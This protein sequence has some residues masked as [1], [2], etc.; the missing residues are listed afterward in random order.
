MRKFWRLLFI[1]MIILFCI[2]SIAIMLG[3]A[4]LYKYSDSRVSEELLCA[5]RSYDE[6]KFYCFDYDDRLYQTGEAR[7]IKDASLNSGIEYKYTSY[8][9]MPENLVLAFVAVEDKR[10]YTHKGIDYKRSLGAVLNYVVGGKKSFG[11]STITQQLVKNLTGNNAMLVERKLTEAFSAMELEKSFEKSEIIEMYL[12]IIN[13]SRGCR[14]VGAAAEFYFSKS[15]SELDLREC[16]CLA[17][18]TNNPS[19]YDPIAHPEANKRRRDI[20]L[21]CM[22]DAGYISHAQY[23]T[24]VSQETRITAKD[25]SGRRINSWYIDAVIRDVISDFAAKYDI[26][27]E[28]ASVLLYKGGYRIYT[29]MDAEIQSIL[30]DHFADLGNFPCD[31]NGEFPQS[32]MIIIDPHSG[33]ILGIAGGIGEKRG[34]RIQSFATDTKR[35]PGSAIKPLSVYAPAIEQGLINWATVIEDSPIKID[36]TTGNGWPSNANKK[37]AGNVNVRCAVANSLNTVAVKVLRMLGNEGSYNFLTNDLLIRSLDKNRDMGDASLALGQPSRGITLRELT[38]AYSIFQNGMMSESRT[39]YKVTDSSGRIILDNS[40][41][42]R[43]VISEKTATIMT[44]LLGEVVNNGTASGY[45]ALAE[46][47]DVAGKTGTSQS[48]QDKYFIGY[49][50]ELL[51]G[52]WQGYEMPKSIDCFRGNYSACIWDDVMSKIYNETGYFKATDFKIANGVGELSYN[53]Q[54]GEPPSAFDNKDVLEF[55]WFDMSRTDLP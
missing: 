32:S 51:G 48:S 47:M 36:E 42:T 50:P 9:E 43:E 8:S 4:V 16:A 37:Y 34:N 38:A 39:Y 6:T 46:R 27:K 31:E 28:T 3:A 53:K 33:D 17:A 12:N 30:D 26:S 54:T 29:A 40:S 49:T 41:S 35:P 44:K 15:V 2:I 55:G 19:K 5:A 45:I 10:F 1:I 21:S 7:E 24:A 14:G 22:L 23:E 20:V 52:V 18:I 11:G 13:L 25:R